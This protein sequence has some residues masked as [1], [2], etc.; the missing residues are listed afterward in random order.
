M[1]QEALKTSNLE[2]MSTGIEILVVEDS[3]TQA[4]KLKYILEKQEYAVRLA[5]NGREGL[6]AIEQRR[7]TMV[8]SDV[9]MPEMDGYEFCSTIK[10][11]DDLK[12]IP[13]ILL[14]TLSDPQDIIR[15]LESGADNFLNKPYSEEALM[16]RIK[17]ILINMDVRSRTRTGMGIE[18]YFAN[19]KHYLTSERIQIIDLLLSTYENAVEKNRE[20][21]QTNKKLRNVQE[22]L[23]KN[24]DQLR[25]LNE[26]KNTLLGMAAHDLRNPLY[27]IEGYSDFLLKDNSENLSE[28][29]RTIISA[30]QSSSTYMVTMIN[31]LLDVQKI[32]TGN[33]EMNFQKGNFHTLVDTI[34]ERQAFA[35][36]KKGVDI[37]VNRPEHIPDFH[38]DAARIEQV[39]SNL[40]DNAVKFSFKGSVIEIQYQ[41][42]EKELVFSVRDHGPGIPE[43]EL[44]RLFKPFSTTSV[45]PTGNE[46]STGLGLAIA[47]SIIEKH[48]GRIWVES[49]LGKGS[50]FSFSLP[51]HPSAT[52]DPTS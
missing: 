44:N 37:T 27:L 41:Y 16:S 19:K 22:E 18:I 34:L 1:K 46:R 45:K 50:T 33:L 15:G 3:P 36:K 20:L 26:Q 6:E 23:E 38:F 2:N 42:D 11:D 8:I 7:P 29:Q 12:D 35:V 48:T 52:V 31:D 51:V 40:I 10:N 14:T 30:V 9:L 4:L 24:N 21:E 5:V 43:N 32:E 28:E 17:Y 13:V 47:R 25:L 39:V 49:E